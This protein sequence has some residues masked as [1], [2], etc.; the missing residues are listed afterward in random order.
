[1]YLNNSEYTHGVK[2]LGSMPGDGKT[3]QSA[4]WEILD[5][6]L[7]APGQLSGMGHAE[8]FHTSGRVFLRPT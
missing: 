2:T 4:C 5:A 7:V 1:M 6:T 8:M 3:P